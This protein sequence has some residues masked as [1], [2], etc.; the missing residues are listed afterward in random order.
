MR[1][2]AATVRAIRLFELLPE[3][4]MITLSAAIDL[5]GTTKPT[6][7]KAIDALVRAAILEEITGKL[8]D[9]VYAYRTYLNALAESEMEE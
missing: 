3:H 1:H 5:L 7:A 4:P 2:K 9:R 6:A 8:R